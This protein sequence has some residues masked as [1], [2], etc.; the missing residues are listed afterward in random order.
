MSGFNVRN[1]E[2]VIEEMSNCAF[3]IVTKSKNEFG[4]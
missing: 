2:I 1:S 4:N 3:L